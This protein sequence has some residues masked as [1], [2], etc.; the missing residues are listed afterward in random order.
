MRKSGFTLLELLIVMAIMAM[1]TAGVSLAMRD[2]A[3]T[4]LE[5]D[6]QRLAVLFESARAQSRTTGI[7]VY[8]HTTDNGFADRAGRIHRRGAR[9]QPLGEARGELRRAERAQFGRQDAVRDLADPSLVVAGREFDQRAPGR[10]Q[11]RQAGQ[12]L[13]NRAQRP[14]AVRRVAARPDDAR[15]LAFAQGYAHQ[16]AGR[17]LGRMRVVEGLGQAGVLRRLDR[18]AKTNRRQRSR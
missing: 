6:A 7:G 4:A 2:N 17:E 3:Q 5:R 12:R 9:S 18:D 1:A 13:D 8:W 15:Y 14:L 11:R 16:R 10:S